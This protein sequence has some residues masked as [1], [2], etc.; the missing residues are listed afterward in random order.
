MNGPRILTSALALTSLLAALAAGGCGKEQTCAAGLQACGGTCRA[1]DTDP[2]HC[3]A[4]GVA[5]ADGEACRAGQCTTCAQACGDGQRC[6]AGLCVADVYAACFDTNDVRGLNAA[7][8]SAGPVLATDQG[9]LSMAVLGDRLHVAN[10]LS[11]TLST[12]SFD[13]PV[14]ATSGASSIHLF[15]AAGPY[16]PDLEYVAA[17]PDGL[18]YVSNAAVSTL[19]VV[20]PA[21]GRVVD[22]LALDAGSN[23][24]GIGFLG[25]KAYLALNGADQIAVLDVAGERGCAP[26]DPAAPACDASCTAPRTCVNG[27]CQR[28]PC[29][30]LL[31]RIDVS[32]LAA[33]AIGATAR[34]FRVAVAG[35]RVF[36]SLNNLRPR[37]D[38]SPNLEPAGAGRVAVVDAA[39]DTVDLATAITLPAVCGDAT[40]LAVD[41][42]TLWVTCGKS[43]FEPPPAPAVEGGALVAVDLGGARPTVR[44]ALPFPDAAPGSVAICGGQGYAGDAASGTVFRFDPATGQL[45]GSATVCPAGPFGAYIPSIACAPRP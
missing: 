36:V 31:K 6:Q 41:G 18:L 42:S 11:N 22:E 37:G 23:P 26:P 7:L 15:G 12:V 30:R 32:S 1:L 5:C 24:Q 38:G 43:T 34:P 17:G 45:T 21:T 3:G 9:P 39:S 25:T 35:G 27:L 8:A 33:P 29:G 20:D 4:C 14:R 40:D 19:V 16:G 44:S 13:P 10:S 28:A 2:L